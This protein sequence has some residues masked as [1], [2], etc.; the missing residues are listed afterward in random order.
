MDEAGAE[1]PELDAEFA[2]AEVTGVLD[3]PPE[4][5]IAMEE[6]PL[7]PLTVDPVDTA[8]IPEVAFP[9]SISAAAVAT[10]A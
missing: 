9:F 3:V 5:V 2:P 7:V 1:V 10:P 6:P 8:V 4:L